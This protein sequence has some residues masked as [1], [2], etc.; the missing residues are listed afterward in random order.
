MFTAID[1]AA[2]SSVTVHVGRGEGA[3]ALYIGMLNLDQKFSCRQCVTQCYSYVFSWISKNLSYC[4][5][6]P[7]FK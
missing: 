1:S 4:T 2:C 6:M 5:K 7:K 3:D